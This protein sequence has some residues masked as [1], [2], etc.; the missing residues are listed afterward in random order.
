MKTETWPVELDGFEV[1]DRT[2]QAPA[3]QAKKVAF[4]SVGAGGVVRLN[5][6]ATAM[7]G[8]VEAVKIMYDPKHQRLGF[9]PTDPEAANSYEVGNFQVYFCCRKLFEYYGVE[10]FESRRYYG[11]EM[12]DG[13]LVAN[14]GEAERD[15]LG[16]S[17]S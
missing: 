6:A 3:G 13:I 2:V 5:K 17:A 16:R 11:L 10:F 12:V 8:R 4:V 15:R 14:I 9:V 1:W 7:L